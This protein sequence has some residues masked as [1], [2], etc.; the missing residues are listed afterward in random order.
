MSGAF[1]GQIPAVMSAAADSSG[2]EL[3]E[4]KQLWSNSR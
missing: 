4:A 3:S 1:I 2:G